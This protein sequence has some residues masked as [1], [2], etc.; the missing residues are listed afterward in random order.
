MPSVYFT[1]HL[2]CAPCSKLWNSRMTAAVKHLPS[3][4]FE[5]SNH[6]QTRSH[7]GPPHCH[8]SMVTMNKRKS[9]V[10]R[11]LHCHEESASEF[12]NLAGIIY[13]NSHDEYGKSGKCTFILQ[14]QHSSYYWFGVIDLLLD[15]GFNEEARVTLPWSV[16]LHRTQTRISMKCHKP[17]VASAQGSAVQLQMDAVKR[18]EIFPV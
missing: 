6:Y 18:I 5:S 7:G 16:K 4:M 8:N 12:K 11:H 17:K 3:G 15:K 13:E 2:L 14:S 1:L 10:T 9:N